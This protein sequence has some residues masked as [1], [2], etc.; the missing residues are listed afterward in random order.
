MI[1]L[2]GGALKF[3]NL[4][5][6]ALKHISININRNITHDTLHKYIP[7]DSYIYDIELKYNIYFVALIC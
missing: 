3:N 4:N 5:P 7:L 1:F 2:Q 6:K